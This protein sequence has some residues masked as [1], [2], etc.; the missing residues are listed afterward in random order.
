MLIWGDVASAVG[1]SKP[2][3]KLRSVVRSASVETPSLQGSNSKKGGQ[4]QLLLHHN[5]E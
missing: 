2:H 3:Y 5:N 4:G 1:V